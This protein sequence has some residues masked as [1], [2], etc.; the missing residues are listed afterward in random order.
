MAEKKEGTFL[1]NP[2]VSSRDRGESVPLSGSDSRVVCPQKSQLLR[3]SCAGVDHREVLVYADHSLF[4]PSV[5][6]PGVECSME[7]D[8]AEP[9]PSGPSV[10]SPDAKR[11]MAININNGVS[12]RAAHKAMR[13][14]VRIETCRQRELEEGRPP[15]PT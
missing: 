4:G 5:N 7:V 13:K 9:P 2:D 10:D 12:V 11:Q 3:E 8:T 14:R 6:V 15:G 1:Y